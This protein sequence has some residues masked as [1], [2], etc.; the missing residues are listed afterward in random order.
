MSEADVVDISGHILP[1]VR[2]VARTKTNQSSCSY[3]YKGQL[4]ACDIASFVIQC[5]WRLLYYD[6]NTFRLTY[7]L[8]LTM[9]PRHKLKETCIH[10][11]L[12][13]AYMVVPLQ[14]AVFSSAEKHVFLLN[15]LIKLST[16]LSPHITQ[17]LAF[18]S[19]AL[20]LTTLRGSILEDAVPSSSKH[21]MP[22]GLPLK[23]VLEYLV[24]E[25]NTH[26]LRLALNTPKVTE[27]LMKLDEQGVCLLPSRFHTLQFY[28]NVQHLHHTLLR[29]ILYTSQWHCCTLQWCP[30]CLPAA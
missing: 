3:L 17:M 21:G 13:K 20:Q 18:L 24:P 28:Q 26:C 30:F 8:T 19:I 10:I 9:K 23:E 1:L 7:V 29:L 27:Q 15:L 6:W 14:A 25:M 4:N 11:Y 2:H 22:R 5:F 12:P 16:Y